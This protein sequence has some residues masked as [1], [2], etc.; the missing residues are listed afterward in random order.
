MRVVR[1]EPDL[2]RERDVGDI[3]GGAFTLYRQRFGLFASIALAVVIP[4]DVLVYG[5]AGKL[6]WEN[7]G[8]T[9]SVSTTADVLA[10]L[11]PYMLL[12]PLIT[13]GHV[14]AVMDLAEGR[15]A[16]AGAALAAAVRRL[17]AVAPAIVLSQLGATLALLLLI[18][19]GVYLWVSWWVAPQ[20]VVAEQVGPIEG[21]RRSRWLVKGNWWRVFGISLLIGLTGGLLAWALGIPL[22]AVGAI[23]DSGIAVLV[24]EIVVGAV[25]YSFT[26]LAGTLLYFDLRARERS[27]P[28]LPGGYYPQIPP[29]DWDAPERP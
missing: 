13:A 14:R 2:S 28:R 17:P 7:H 8:F 4:V 11:S 12:T 21:I 22:I 18:I 25:A 10:V 26:A 15:D 16:S 5:V 1:R 20:A 23:A 29:V 6:L 9:E 24:G 3:L 27:V 19:P